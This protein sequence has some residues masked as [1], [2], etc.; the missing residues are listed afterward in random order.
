MSFQL[1]NHAYDWHE[2]SINSL[3]KFKNEDNSRLKIFS[4]QR[5]LM[6]GMIITILKYCKLM[7]L[8]SQ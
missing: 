2:E 7:L 8:V 3:L 1:M 4:H 5:Q 6:L